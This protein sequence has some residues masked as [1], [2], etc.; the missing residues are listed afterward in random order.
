[1]GVRTLD[2]VRRLLPG[3]LTLLLPYPDEFEYPA[4]GIV[5]AT[6]RRGRREVETLGVRVPR[7]PEAARV[8]GALPFPLLASSANLSG[9]APPRSLDEMDPE[10]LAAC[11][12]V[13]DGGR[14]AGIASTLVDLASYEETRRW[15]LLRAGLVGE[16]EVGAMLAC[17]RD[18]LPR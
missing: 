4:P 5:V 16:D 10:V 13:L 17:R 7:W 2:A 12:L 15:R 8:L 11:D 14:I 6:A 9:A 1:M 3:G 18:D